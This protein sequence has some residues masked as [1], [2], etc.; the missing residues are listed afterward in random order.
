MC[1]IA[2]LLGGRRKYV[3]ILRGNKAG[4]FASDTAVDIEELLA[5]RVLRTEVFGVK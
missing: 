2:E 4:M 3:T 1:V 5:N